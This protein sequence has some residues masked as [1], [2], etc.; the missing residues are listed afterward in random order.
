M[1]QGDCNG[2]S[3]PDLMS[4]GIGIVIGTGIFTLTSVAA[5]AYDGPAV[6]PV[7]RARG[8]GQPALGTLLRRAG[9]A[10]PAA[11]SAYTY[12]YA[13][14]GEI[15]AWIMAGGRRGLGLE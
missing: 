14:I 1:S 8:R 12:A 13:T 11:G 9:A 10:V 2:G 3:A 15:F 4:F 7:R 6:M 5:K